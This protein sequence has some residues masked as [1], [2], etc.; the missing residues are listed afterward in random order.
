MGAR[1]TALLVALAVP[2]DLRLS[3][4]ERLADGFSAAC[5][6]LAPGCAVVGG[7]LTVSDVLTIAVTALG[8]LEGRAPVTRDGA[9]PGRRRGR[10]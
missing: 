6:A 5:D 2:R 8:D 4:V 3:F 1:P 9:R 10:R 7:D